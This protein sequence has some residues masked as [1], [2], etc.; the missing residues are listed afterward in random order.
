M[1]AAPVDL[2]LSSSS[3]SFSSGT[4]FTISLSPIFT[5]KSS[6]RLLSVNVSEIARFCD[7]SN[8]RSLKAT[9][10]SRSICSCLRVSMFLTASS[11]SDALRAFMFAFIRS[12]RC[13]IKVMSANKISN[14]TF[15]ISR[16]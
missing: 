8:V 15:S 11:R 4:V 6:G 5:A 2:P 13:S 1:I 10:S 12:I 3:N 9:P 7:E 14:A 16:L